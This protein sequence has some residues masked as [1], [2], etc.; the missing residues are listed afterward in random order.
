M[1]IFPRRERQKK[2]KKISRGQ[3]SS[4]RS[5]TDLL[6]ASLALAHTH[7]RT[8]TR[9]RTRL[10]LIARMRFSLKARRI[11]EKTKK[12]KKTS[13]E[14]KDDEGT[15]ATGAKTPK[16]RRRDLFHA[17]TRRD[18]PD[19]PYQMA[20]TGRGMIGLVPL[21]TSDSSASVELQVIPLCSLFLNSPTASPSSL[22][23]A[24]VLSSR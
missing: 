17:D 1:S 8:R 19:G 23:A 10:A 18:S 15:P 2:A 11:M 21:A 5:D 24:P 4:R 6:D 13:P 9:K 7:T 3:N 12:A 20:A 14:G 16:G 22:L